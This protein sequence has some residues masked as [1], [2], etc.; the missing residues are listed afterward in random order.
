MLVR[1]FVSRV[2]LFFVVSLPA[3][4]CNAVSLVPLSGFIISRRRSRPPT[5]PHALAVPEPLPPDSLSRAVP[6]APRSEATS[7]PAG[8]IAQCA[9]GRRQIKCRVVCD[10]QIS[11]TVLSRV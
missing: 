3:C 11:S 10:G 7:Q 5:V 8:M 4:D 9:P 2:C 6:S 1:P